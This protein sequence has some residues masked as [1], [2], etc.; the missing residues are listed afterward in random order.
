VTVPGGGTIG[1]GIALTVA[2][3]E[4]EHTVRHV[5]LD[6]T[7]ADLIVERIILSQ[8]PADASLSEL[9]IE[10]LPESL[11]LKRTVMQE[12]QLCAERG[13]TIHS[14]TAILSISAIAEGLPSSELYTGI[15]MLQPS[16]ADVA[17]GSCSR[18]WRSVS[19]QFDA[20]LMFLK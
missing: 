12:V 1:R 8:D 15:Q 11:E 3:G 19:R 10:A 16:V 18:R 9:V 17:G 4:G 14:N 2:R 7:R 5:C 20:A 13:I 6:A